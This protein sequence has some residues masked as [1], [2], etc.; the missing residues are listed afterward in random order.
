MYALGKP[1]QQAVERLQAA[2]VVVVPPSRMKRGPC[3]LVDMSIYSADAGRVAWRARALAMHEVE[4]PL[5]VL[6]SLM[7]WQTSRS[8]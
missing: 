3:G 5:L 1:L 2:A 6:E 4:G 7:V 8:I